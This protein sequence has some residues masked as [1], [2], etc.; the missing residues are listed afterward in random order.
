MKELFKII[1]SIRTNYLFAMYRVHMPSER[2]KALI[3]L[4]PIEFKMDMNSERVGK[5]MIESARYS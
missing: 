1:L 5:F 2:G 4:K 3:S